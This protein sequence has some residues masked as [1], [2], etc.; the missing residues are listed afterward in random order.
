M[1]PFIP[2]RRWDYGDAIPERVGR[3]LRG[4]DTV[5]AIGTTGGV[6]YEWL[7]RELTEALGLGKR[8][9]L[10]VDPEIAVP[11]GLEPHAVRIDRQNFA[12]TVELVAG[13]MEQ[14]KLEKEQNRLFTWLAVGGIL[15]M[16]L[17]S[18]E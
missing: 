17:S 18:K 3:H 14:M 8:V 10:A 4:S 12:K 5:L 6:H 9:L 7:N 11:P 1:S 13:H 16:L 15:A 2:D